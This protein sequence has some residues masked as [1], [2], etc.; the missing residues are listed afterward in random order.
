MW[1]N[2][3]RCCDCENLDTSDRN[4]YGEAYC[5]VDRDYVRLDSHTCS[6]FVPN[7]YV[8]TVYCKIKGLPYDCKEM[9]TLIN[10]RDNY[11]MCNDDGKEFLCDYENIGPLIAARLKCDI[12]KMDVVETMCE[13]YIIPAIEFIN[14]QRY[15]EAQET[16]IEMI[17]TLK[18]RYGYLPTKSKEKRKDFKF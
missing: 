14:E 17:E 7:F 4:K 3:L 10:F 5:P 1:F 13:N 9:T 12:Y 15:D 8:M 6:S 16:Y 18:I 11:M 2:G